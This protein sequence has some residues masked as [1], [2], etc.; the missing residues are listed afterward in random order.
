MKQYKIERINS[1]FNNQPF[2][3]THLSSSQK[4]LGKQN[5]T[6]QNYTRMNRVSSES[7]ARPGP[8]PGPR[9]KPD[10]EHS[11]LNAIA[12]IIGII[13]NF[14][15]TIPLGY[16]FVNFIE[17]WNLN[18][19]LGKIGLIV[20]ALV[21]ISGCLHTI[22]AMFNKIKLMQLF[23][24]I[25]AILVLISMA[26]ATKNNNLCLLG[27]SFTYTHQWYFIFGWLG[28]S[29]WI[30]SLILSFVFNPPCEKK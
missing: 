27:S 17:F 12:G 15:V 18:N 22:L 25:N 7:V 9:P 11:K 14:F 8:S 24:I 2:Y 4:I 21:Q 29:F 19:T 30:V 13:A 6:A 26:I 16:Y 5:S 20:F 3:E 28:F 1:I 23:T 10:R